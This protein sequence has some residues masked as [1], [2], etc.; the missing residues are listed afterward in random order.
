MLHNLLKYSAGSSLLSLV[1]LVALKY[2]QN[3]NL[4]SLL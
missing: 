2:Y 3:L 1:G 4:G